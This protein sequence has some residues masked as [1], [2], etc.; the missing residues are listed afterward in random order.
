MGIY[1]DTHQQPVGP[2]KT[3]PFSSDSVLDRM[4]RGDFKPTEA[5][6]QELRKLAQNGNRAERRAAARHL[7]K[8]G[9]ATPAPAAPRAPVVMPPPEAAEVKPRAAKQEPA[10]QAQP[11]K[12]SAPPIAA[13]EKPKAIEKP[14]A[15]EKPGAKETPRAKE[16]A[17]EGLWSRIT[18]GTKAVAKKTAA[19]K[20]APKKAASKTRAPTKAT[21]TTAVKKT[22]AKKATAKKPAK[23]SR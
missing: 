4:T 17:A 1:G 14:K 9:I 5:D 13:K 3:S 10:K 12:P 20:A 7:K 15:P 16:A 21:K 11:H 19:K 23:K 8:Q 6:L 22:A 18:G 2:V